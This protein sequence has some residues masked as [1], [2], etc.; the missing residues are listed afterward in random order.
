[1]FDRGPGTA[2]RAEVLEQPERVRTALQEVS[3]KAS[4]L[5]DLVAESEFV[6]LLG[7]GSSRSAC[8]YGA[9]ALQQLA[10]KPAFLGSPTE[11]AWGSS[12]LPLE[13]GLVVAVSQSG[14]S[15][16][17]V[18]AARHVVEHG[19]SLVVIT[20]VEDSTLA[21]IADDAARLLRC[22]AGAELAVPATKSFT[23]SLACL[24]GLALA[25]DPAR[26]AEVASALPDAM[27]SALDGAGPNVDLSSLDGLVLVGEGYGA[28]IA[29]EGAIKFRE[30]LKMLVA[31]LETSEFL[32]GSITAAQPGIGV[33]ALALDELGTGLAQQVV[34]QAA[35]RGALTYAVG[36]ERIV[37]ADHRTIV[38]DLGDELAPFLAICHLQLVA[39]ASGVAAGLDPDAPVGLQKITR[40]AGGVS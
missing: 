21:G 33:I 23:T 40:I 27:Q 7:R 14:E 29:E 13:R 30:I 18:A 24:L 5:R 39:L 38:P 22:H 16:E 25:H 2:M 6:L 19:G 34:D 37:G 36:S 15:R 28:A 1:M 31:S 3:A 20:N 10:G 17:M 26:L 11:V 9:W 12:G 4:R 35:E 8:S 32:H